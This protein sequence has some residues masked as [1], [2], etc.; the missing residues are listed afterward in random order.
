MGW[1]GLLRAQ[2]QTKL[3]ISPV[4]FELTANPGDTLSNQIKVTNVSDV[5]LQLE[6]KVEN[7]AGT[8]SKGQ[9]TLTSEET[10]FSLSSWVK[11]DPTRFSL[12]PKEVRIITY[13]IAVPL[14]AE[15]GG[16]YG[17]ILVG[18]IASDNLESSGAAV[19]QRLG[20]LVLVRVNGEQR[21][22]ATI[23]RIGAKH[24]NGA[25]DAFLLSDGKTKIQIPK[26]VDLTQEPS[27]NYFSSGPIALETVIHNS[28]NV[29]IKPNGYFT[30]YNLFNQKVTELPLDSRNVFPG[31]D[32]NITIVWPVKK[33][34]GIYY[35]AQLAAVYGSTNQPLTASFS[36]WAFPRFEALGIAAGLLLLLLLRKRLARALRILVKGA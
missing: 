30:I 25:T 10:E 8:G 2:E 11:T 15:P 29:H 20:S 1:F 24:Y 28:G 13:T 23:K 31:N 17:T 32:R 9:V 4:T 34:R 21:E 27:R 18:T 14:N 16:H 5:T 26:N 12:K 19:V 35:R 22:E 3:T 6:T 33:P 7:I 36:F